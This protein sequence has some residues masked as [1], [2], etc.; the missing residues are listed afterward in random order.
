MSV[1]L[2]R[3]AV[4]TVVLLLA[5]GPVS[6][7]VLDANVGLTADT[8]SG[9]AMPEGTPATINVT[10]NYSCGGLSGTVEVTAEPQVEGATATVSNSSFEAESPPDCTVGSPATAQKVVVTVEATKDII[11]ESLIPV[12]VKVTGENAVMAEQDG[13]LE[14]AAVAGPYVDVTFTPEATEFE[15]TAGEVVPVRIDIQSDSNTLIMA[16]PDL[17]RPA[18]PPTWPRPSIFPVNVASPLEEGDGSSAFQFDVKVP[19]GTLTGVYHL[20]FTAFAHSMGEVNLEDPPSDDPEV[21]QLTFNVEGV[22]PA[23]NETNESPGVGAFLP[24]SV[25]LGATALAF[26]RRRD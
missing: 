2:S 8:P 19:D 11:D 1:L 15:T 26:L 5:A 24:M 12:L 3:I 20:N 4:I 23:D 14:V 7:Q 18:G 9:P 22:D 13:E 6:A 16:M 25:L 10:I 21:I 17:E